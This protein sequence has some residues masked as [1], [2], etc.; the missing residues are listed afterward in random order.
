MPSIKDNI[1]HA[2]ENN[3]DVFYR[4]SD[5]R[6]RIRCPFCGDSQNDYRKAHMYL[7]CDHNPNTPILYYCFKGNCGAR[8]KVDKDFLDRLHIKV[9][10]IDEF[11]NK[12]YN[13]ISNIQK[14]KI[15]IVTGKPIPGS[16]QIRYI[17][18]RLGKGLTIEDYDRFKIVWDINGLIPYIS[19]QRVINTLPSNQKSISFLSEDK[20]CLLTRMFE[21]TEFDRWKKTKLY[22]N[23]NRIFYTIKSEIDLFSDDEI[24]V[25][26]A[27]GVFDIIGVYK[28]FPSKNSIYIACLASD[29]ECGLQFAI[30]KGFIGKNI[31]VNI[32]MDDNIDE[33][34]LKKRLKRF[35]WIIGSIYLY[36]NM[37]AKDFGCK[38]ENIEMVEHQ[39][40]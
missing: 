28:H 14:V 2:L 17:E 38:F 32:Y 40:Q 4:V 6:Y 10:G 19:N 26:V 34:L 24:V 22:P 5:V 12:V 27:E 1:I 3:L 13:K 30:H 16:K 15:D 37:K 21:E 8:G 9:D 7:L 11:S 29:Y 25:N 39:I 20:S 35:R 23:E 33:T 18:D 36:R 31:R